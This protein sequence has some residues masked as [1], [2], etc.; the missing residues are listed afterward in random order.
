MRLNNYLEIFLAQRNFFGILKTYIYNGKK[1]ETV[2][3][4]EKKRIIQVPFGRK[5]MRREKLNRIDKNIV[6]RA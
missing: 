4:K 1:L 6:D 2:L 5:K 3:N